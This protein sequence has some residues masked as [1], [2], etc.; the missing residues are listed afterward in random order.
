MISPAHWQRSLPLSA[1]ILK[2]NT[3]GDGGTLA[4]YM[5]TGKDG[6]LAEF[7][8]S[9]GLDFFSSDPLQAFGLMQSMAEATTKSTMPFFHG[10][11]NC[12]EGERLTEKQ[13][14]ETVDR[15]E[16]RLRF[17]GQPRLITTHTDIETGEQNYHVAWFRMDV[18]RERIINPGLYPF[19]L[20]D[21][22]RK[23]EKDFGLQIVSSERKADDRARAADRDEFEE[24]RRLGTDTRA[25]RNAILDCFEKSDNGKSFAAAI[26]AHGW[27][28]ANGDRDNF[29]VINHAGGHHALN[30]KLTGKT[31]EEIRARLADLDRSQ[32]PSVDQ[33]KELQT[34][35][36]AARAPSFAKATA[37]RQPEIKPLGQTAGEIRMAWNVTR[38]RGANELVEEI[39]KRGLQ[40]VYV[41]ADEAKASERAHAFAKAINRQNRALKEGFAVVDRRGTVT[42]IDQ[43][44]TGDQWEE[45]Q[46]RLG[47]I[48]TRELMSVADAR[49]V[50]KEA[51]RAEWREQRQAAWNAARAPTQTETKI[52]DADK[53]T[54]G[55]RQQFDAELERQGLGLARVTAS[56][57]AALDA[58]NRDAVYTAAAELAPDAVR[59]FPV[60]A[61]GELA[62]VDHYG[63]VHK[64]NPHH[65]ETIE[66]RFAEPEPGSLVAEGAAQW[67]PPPSLT[68]LR[69]EFETAKEFRAEYFS[70]IRQAYADEREA[71]TE[72]RLE[73]DADR[74]TE[75][76]WDLIFTGTERATDHTAAAIEDAV[77]TGI[78]A[79]SGAASAVA[80]AVESIFSA[81]ADFLGF[82]A[83]KLTPD[84]AER[85]HM[86]DA[87]KA[88]NRAQWAE[89]AERTGAQDWL[90][91]E[92]QR[93]QAARDA[94]DDDEPRRTRRDHTRERD[95]DD[96][97]R[98]RGRSL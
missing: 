14:L 18:E 56:D 44:T 61:E 46:K 78:T 21:E 7:V 49:D 11:I 43:R 67:T 82:G 96:D 6:E 85:K 57:I 72:A 51:S 88:D 1:M 90:V 24:G 8:Q 4:R 22:A 77:D 75:Q 34:Q 31:L 38:H 39:E 35:R 42:R 97:Q 16:K 2:G 63:G 9:R 37:D 13:L 59:F 81:V 95:D 69:A 93:A 15:M 26:K 19:R 54:A 5:L 68:E 52:L 71:R 40:L 36:Q 32:L 86:A 73:Q 98:R 60:L 94:A 87:E 27:E 45:I 47:G 12:A 28:L 65:L 74:A 70:D 62:A 25:I 89:I 23:I 66:R 29:V 80:K 84:Q 76:K 91:A 17:T 58:L 55:D 10:Q 53:A 83:V 48:D 3:H 30:K 50:M 41:T 64:L 20:I 33:A 79:A 92:M